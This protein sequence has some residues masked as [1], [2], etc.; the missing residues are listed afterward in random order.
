MKTTSN[1]RRDEARSKSRRR[2]R[3][4][5]RFTR[6]DVIEIIMLRGKKT[7]KTKRNTKGSHSRPP[8]G[9]ITRS[10]GLATLFLRDLRT[11][12]KFSC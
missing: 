6:P 10:I 1:K 9:Y 11:Y 3:K 7:K 4:R 5:R 12:E 8:C 2:R